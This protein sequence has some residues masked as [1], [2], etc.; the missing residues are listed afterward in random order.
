M[1]ALQQSELPAGTSGRVLERMRVFPQPP[2][3]FLDDPDGWATGRLAIES[4]SKPREI[5]ESVARNRH[6]AV[7]ACHDSAKTHT[8]A[9][10]ACW[11]LDVHKVGEAFVVSTAPS[12][13]QVETLL[14]GE[15]RSMHDDAGLAG[16]ITPAAARWVMGNDEL[17]AFGRKSADE[18]DPRKAMQSFQGKHARYML[19]IIDEAGGVPK[20]LF[21]A[22]DSLASNRNARVLAIGNPDD[23]TS[24]FATVCGPGSKYHVIPIS[25]FDTPAFTGEPVS[26]VLRDEHLISHEYVE[27]MAL[28]GVDSHLYRSK[29]LGEF[30]ET[31]DDT[32]CPVG[33]VVQA[34]AR[35]LDA[36]QQP[37]IL[38]CD[39]ARFGSDE[40]VLATRRG[41]RVRIAKTYVGRDTMQTVGEISV[42]ARSLA[43]E[44][45]VPKEFVQIVVDDVGVGGGVTDR[46]RELGEFQVIAFNGGNEPLTTDYPNRRSELWFAFAEQLREIDLDPDKKLAADLVAPH[47]KLDSRGRRVVEAK[48]ETKKRLGRSPDR[49]DAVLLTF[50]APP[51]VKAVASTGEGAR[52]FDLDQGAYEL[53]RDM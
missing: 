14:W 38:A 6:T 17:V 29:V 31:S 42:A 13:H 39:V 47:Y 36:T 52:R 33:Q 25:A 8:A 12:Q 3:P 44:S 28:Y 10:I 50:A 37:V 45:K 1:T 46:L 27:E 5:R 49:A 34:Q 35:D 30:P 19:V 21:D 22:V 26:E 20:W 51:R 40:T 32:V 41:P 4:W 53:R 43:R 23:P 7:P 9:S 15:I 16:R 24:H 18:V 48:A 2:D 11:W